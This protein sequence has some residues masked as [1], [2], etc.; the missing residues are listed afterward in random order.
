MA[1]SQCLRSKHISRVCDRC[2]KQP[3]KQLHILLAGPG[4]YCDRPGCCPACTGDE[5]TKEAPARRKREGAL[6][7]M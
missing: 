2:G 5:G 7:A 3:E 6:S 1:S 4:F